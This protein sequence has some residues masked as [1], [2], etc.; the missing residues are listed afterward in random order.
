MAVLD[1][2]YVKIFIALNTIDKPCLIILDQFENLLN[3]QTGYA[4]QDRPG[5]GEWIDIINSHH[6]ACR[7]LLTSRLWPQGTSNYPSTYMQ[8]FQVKGLEIREGV[9]LLKKLGAGI[10]ATD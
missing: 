6:C 2:T 10:G 1:K 4:H 9:E 5:I 3:W 7:L 8:E